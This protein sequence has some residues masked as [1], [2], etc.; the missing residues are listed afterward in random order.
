MLYKT[1][2]CFKCKCCDTLPENGMDQNLI[3]ILNEAGIT[4]DEVNC[5]YRCV[6]HNAEVGGEENS[7][8]LLGTAADIDA[9]NVEELAQKFESLLADGVGRYD[10]FV[11]VDTRSGRIGDDY[12]W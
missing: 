7:Q 6:K 9:N 3:D 4:A 2:D 10:N 1:D 12:R 11:H 5:G 8:H